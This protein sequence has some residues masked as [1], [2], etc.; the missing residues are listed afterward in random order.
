M[1]TCTHL[2]CNVNGSASTDPNGTIASYAWT[3][4]DGGTG[5]GATSSH[6]YEN[7]G[8]YTISLTVTDND[9]LTGSTTRTV[10]VTAPPPVTPIAFRNAAS[11]TGN[12]APTVGQHAGQRRGR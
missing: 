10:N 8:S 12:V 2:A 3:Y 6:T 1:P 9:G 4:G 7:A 5:T 11:S